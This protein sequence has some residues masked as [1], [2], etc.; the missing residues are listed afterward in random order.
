M[1]IQDITYQF[2]QQDIQNNK[3]L[4]IL[5]YLGAFIILPLLIGKDSPY[6]KQNV[7]QGLI[8]CLASVV[9]NV[10]AGFLIF[11]PFGSIFAMAIN[12]CIW[13]V[14]I[15]AIYHIFMGRAVKFPYIG[16]FEIIK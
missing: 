9:L 16:D 11:V 6:V 4:A 7:N 15:T 8:I 14:A 1:M 13:S 2:S 5:A 10:F 12:F 3:I